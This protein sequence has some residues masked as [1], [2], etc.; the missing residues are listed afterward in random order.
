MAAKKK[1]K[2][3]VGLSRGPFG[4]TLALFGAKLGFGKKKKKK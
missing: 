2:K 4:H 1:S 3:V